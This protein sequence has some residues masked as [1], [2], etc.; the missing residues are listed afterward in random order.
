MFE[1]YDVTDI[2]LE[3]STQPTY[4]RLHETDWPGELDAEV[5]GVDVWVSAADAEHESPVG[6]LVDITGL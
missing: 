4:V 6:K 2:C 3:D 1:F 5:I